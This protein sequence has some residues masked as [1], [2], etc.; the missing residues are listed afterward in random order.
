MDVPPS[1]LAFAVVF[2]YDSQAL[3]KSMDW[4]CQARNVR[5]GFHVKQQ[6]AKYDDHV[7]TQQASV[8]AFFGQNLHD[9]GSHAFVASNFVKLL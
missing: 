1:V 6:K 4:L 7:D 9:N 2:I 8:Q 5:K 3:A